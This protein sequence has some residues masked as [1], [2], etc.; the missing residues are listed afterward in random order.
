MRS[1]P[2]A[3]RSTQHTVEE[4]IPHLQIG[5]RFLQH[6]FFSDPQ[7]VFTPQQL[8]DYVKGD[9]PLYPAGTKVNYSN[10]NTVLLGMVIEQVTGKPFAD[11]LQ[12]GILDPLGMTQTSFPTTSP[13]IPDPYWQGITEQGIPYGTVKNATNWNP[14]WGF[15]AGA[16]ISTLDDLRKWAVALGTGQGIFNA[17]TQAERVKSETSTVPPNSPEMAYALGFGVSNGWIGHTGELPG[18]NTS[19]QYDPKTQTTIV[20]MVNSDIPAGKA[21]PAPTIFN[22]LKAAMS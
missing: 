12:S 6:T 10:T 21:N 7:T 18:F 17:A 4:S 22:E 16:M 14:S 20:V 9:K 19:I 11:S 2:V 5:R 8:I 15:T 1:C 3:Q 13:A